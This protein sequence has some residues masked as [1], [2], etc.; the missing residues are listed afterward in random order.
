MSKNTYVSSNSHRSNINTNCDYIN[1]FPKYWQTDNITPIT[2]PFKFNLKAK[3]APLACPVRYYCKTVY[4]IKY[5]VLVTTDFHVCL[6]FTC[7]I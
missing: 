6:L 7:I 3:P 1:L 5:F 4:N 2:I